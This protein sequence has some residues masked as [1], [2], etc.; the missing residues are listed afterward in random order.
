[1]KKILSLSVLLILIVSVTAH[2]FWLAPKKF[3][4]QVND[5]ATLN[6]K[7]GEHFL[8]DNWKGN[9]SKVNQL[10]YYSPSSTNSIG[11]LLSGNEG[12]SIKIVL[13]EEGTHMVIFNSN[14]SFIE[15]EADKF[16][17]Y[18]KEDGIMNTLTYRKE[19]DGGGR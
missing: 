19:H 9:K 10:L 13:R 2:E 12:D 16:N 18:L 8:G 5:T 14:N 7:V 15:L 6:F 17:A 4:F 3:W 1:M 11:N